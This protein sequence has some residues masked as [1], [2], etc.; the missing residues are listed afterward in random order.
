MP[1][2]RIETIQAEFTVYF[3]W[4]GQKTPYEIIY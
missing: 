3:W 1:V 4:K 2:L